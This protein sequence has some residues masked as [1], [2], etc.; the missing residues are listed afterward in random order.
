VGGSSLSGRLFTLWSLGHEEHTIKPL[1]SVEPEHNAGV[2]LVENEKG[3]AFETLLEQIVADGMVI[4]RVVI[5]VSEV[6]FFKSVLEAY[7]GLAAVH[8]ERAEKKQANAPQDLAPRKAHLVVATTPGFEAELDAL[9]HEMSGEMS[10]AT[11]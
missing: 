8:A 11:A 6:V 10:L 1:F 7:P 9:L 2:P 3:T 4:R 5:P